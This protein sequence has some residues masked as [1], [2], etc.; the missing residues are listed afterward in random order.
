MLAA[1]ARAARLPF[2]GMRHERLRPGESIPA[3][4]LTLELQLDTQHPQLEHPWSLYQ[5]PC[6]EGALTMAPLVG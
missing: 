3:Y 6:V 1:R 4:T 2:K 5:A